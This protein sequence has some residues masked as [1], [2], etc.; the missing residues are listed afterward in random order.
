[1]T[2]DTKSYS[3]WE[4]IRV[5]QAVMGRLIEKGLLKLPEKPT[6]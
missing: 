3:W 5:I 1:M 4:N 2:G 6:A